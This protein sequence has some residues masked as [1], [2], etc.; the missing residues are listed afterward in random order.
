MI[1]HVTNDERDPTAIISVDFIR[2][3]KIT[4]S[5]FANAGAPGSEPNAVFMGAVSQ[6][7]ENVL[8]PAIWRPGSSSI[9]S[10]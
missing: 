1:W 8:P 6:L 7:A 4:N 10:L 5:A 2:D 3:G 9:G